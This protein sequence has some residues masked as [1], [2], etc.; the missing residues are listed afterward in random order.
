MSIGAWQPSPTP[1]A[2]LSEEQVQQLLSLIESD[3]SIP[4]ALEWIEPLAHA[5]TQAWLVASEQLS[6][7]ALVALIRFFT[8][9]EKEQNWSLGER[10]PVIPLFKTLKRSKG[11]DRALVQ[12]IKSHSDNRFLPFGPLL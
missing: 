4:E 6:D 1:L 7:E 12:W 5:D 2:S 11:V 3:Q 9:Q 8:E 10:S